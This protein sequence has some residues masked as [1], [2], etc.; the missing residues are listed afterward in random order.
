LKQNNSYIH[1]DNAVTR[2]TCARRGQR[3][4]L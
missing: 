3:S 4:P 2:L 1:V